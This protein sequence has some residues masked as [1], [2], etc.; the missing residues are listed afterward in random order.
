MWCHAAVLFAVPSA[1]AK[2][3]PIATFDGA[4]GTTFKWETV[5]D[6]VMGGQSY[7]TFAVQGK[8]GQWQGEVKIVPFLKAPGFCNLEADIHSIPDLSAYEGLSL[9]AR[10]VGDSLSGFIIQVATKDAKH[11]FKV[12]EYTANLPALT[13]SFQDAFVPWSAFVCSWRGENVTWCPKLTSQLAKIDGLSIGS[14]FTVPKAGKFHLEIQSVSATDSSGF[15]ASAEAVTVYDFANTK[16][17]KFYEVNDPVMGGASVGSF[18]SVNADVSYGQLNGTVNLIPSLGAPGFIKALTCL[19]DVPTG[20]FSGGTCH[21]KPTFPDVSA[22][23]KFVLRVRTDTPSFAGFKF[24]FGPAPGLFN[25]GYKADFNATKD[26][27]N[28]EIP[29]SSFSGK[30]SG[31]TGEPTKTCAADPSVCPTKSALSSMNDLELWAEG[32][33]GNAVLDVQWIKAM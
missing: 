14:G 7:S 24:S 6:P 16:Q 18:H 33:A 32:H 22:K 20:H 3:L 15:A 1:I 11:G 12:G 25:F 17:V 19:E 10:T 27:S 8:L 4:S 5:N 21:K 30:T 23:S 13:P 29:F 2:S 28:V 9:R 26:W 31:A